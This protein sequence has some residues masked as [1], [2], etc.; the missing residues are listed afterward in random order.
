MKLRDV[1]EE[2]EAQIAELKREYKEQLDEEWGEFDEKAGNW[3][4]DNWKWI[5]LG[6]AAIIL[7]IGAIA[8][9]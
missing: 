1:I 7:I 3:A 9:F 8:L 4:K 6:A 5:A 2:K